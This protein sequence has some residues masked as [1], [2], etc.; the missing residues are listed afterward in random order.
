[1]RNKKSQ[2]GTISIPYEILSLIFLRE[3]ITHVLWQPID[4][5]GYDSNTARMPFSICFITK[6][7][8]D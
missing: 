4:K 1:M 8:K 6:M 7:L 2:R 5:G 3:H